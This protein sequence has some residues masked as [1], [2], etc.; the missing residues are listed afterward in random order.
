MQQDPFIK[1][2]RRDI[3]FLW[4][5]IYSVMNEEVA[6]RQN[7]IKRWYLYFAEERKILAVIDKELSKLTGTKNLG[8]FLEHDGMKVHKRYQL[9]VD[10]LVEKIYSETG[11]ILDISNK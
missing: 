11:Y 1:T 7:K 6:K 10:N 3:G 5:K 9:D 2:L 8:Y 4:N